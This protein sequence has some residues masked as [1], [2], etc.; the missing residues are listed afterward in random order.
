M[1]NSG[2]RIVSVDPGSSAYH[3]GIRPGMRL[4]SLNGRPIRDLIDYRFS[5]DGQPVTVE[6]MDGEA[7]RQLR[8]EE[9]LGMG[10][11]EP[12]FDGVRRCRNRC[13]F[14]FIRGL[15][16]GL[17]R[18][19][20]VKDDDYRLSF[21]YGN[22]ITLT[23]LAEADWGRLAEQRLS[24]L[25]VSVHTTNPDLRRRLMGHPEAGAIVEQLQRLAELGLQAHTQVVLIPGVNDGPELARTVHDLAGLFPTVRSIA[26]VPVG[27]SA[28]FR[29]RS[30]S[31]SLRAISSKEARALLHLVRP[32]RREF[33]RRLGVSLVYASDEVYLQAGVTFPSAA[34]YDGFPQYENG[35][36]L[37]RQLL[38]QAARLRHRLRRQPPAIARAP[39]AVVCGT[40]AAPVLA[41]IL[42]ELGP[43]A[44]SQLSLYPVEN[45]FFGPRVSVSGLLTG[46]DIIAGL[47]GEI[48]EEIIAIHR[49][50]IS[51]RGYFLDG[52]TPKEVSD[53]L[54]RP[55]V[56]VSSLGELIGVGSTSLA[57]EARG[58]ACAA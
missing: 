29:P 38:D 27:S 48:G 45:R 40:L 42:D 10:F 32:W 44:K 18:G 7:R 12:V 41:R 17:R 13:V 21:L 5:A 47:K 15:P 39:V 4:L 46:S 52:L 14:C 25:Y 34:A 53:A 3:A 31:P 28:H 50:L 55:L 35:V 2:G 37:V 9:A 1:A 6:V 33:R 57:P 36:G 22:F 51:A 54:G 24:P 56:M 58:E 19:L 16:R 30:G 49:S 43:L 26:V 23:N 11:G 8:L 20:Y